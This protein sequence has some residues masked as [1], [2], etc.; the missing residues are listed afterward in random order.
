MESIT[1]PQMEKAISTS[2]SSMETSTQDDIENQTKAPK[3]HSHKLNNK[4]H[5]FLM[6]S[7]IICPTLLIVTFII[8]TYVNGFTLSCCAIST[9]I[10]YYEETRW[11]HYFSIFAT[12]VS[13]LL[14]L[15]VTICRQIQMEVIF[16]RYIEQNR[17]TAQTA[18]IY[19]IINLIG[20]IFNVITWILIP[21]F[22]IIDSARFDAH[23][24]LAV[25]AIVCSIIFLFL[26]MVVTFKQ[27][28]IEYKKILEQSEVDKWTAFKNAFFVDAILMLILLVSSIIFILI[29]LVEFLA[30]ED[31]LE[32][33]VEVPDYANISEWIGFMALISGVMVLTL[34]FHDDRVDDEL[35][36][37]W[38]KVYATCG[39]AV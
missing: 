6:S 16:R 29:Y 21:T 20:V 30:T 7:C 8:Q 2:A 14:G 37:F 9:G 13:C 4:F 1:A 10:A 31:R 39:G 3:Q 17:C 27:R 5:Y 25:T 15:F 36:A 22:V 33:G 19:Y 18:K 26:T 24:G 38:K 28:D 35:I 11:C 32:D 12:F 34:T 23:A